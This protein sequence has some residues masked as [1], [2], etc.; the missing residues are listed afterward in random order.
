MEIRIPGFGL[1][2]PMSSQRLVLGI[3]F[4]ILLA[5]SAAS[6]ALDVKSR[7]DVAWINHT[8]EVSNKVTDMRLLF[9]N[10]E[11]AARGYL[12]AN[13][14]SFMEDYHRS[15]EQIAPAFRELK[16]AIKDNAAQ[17]RFARK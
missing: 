4:A 1:N 17:S 10:A 11:S 3:G 8:L 2:F 14:Q 16:E 13:D 9:R 6:I 5:I 15:L 12:L 7:S